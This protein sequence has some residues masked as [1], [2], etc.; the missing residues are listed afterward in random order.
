[1][2][3]FQSSVSFLTYALN[4]NYAFMY[5]HQYIGNFR[6]ASHKLFLPR[7]TFGL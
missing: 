2:P 3:K 7:Q 4:N 6:Y 5:S 1:M